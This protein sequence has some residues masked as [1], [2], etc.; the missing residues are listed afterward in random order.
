MKWFNTA[1]K[2]TS[3]DISM[4]FYNSADLPDGITVDMETI[5]FNMYFHMNID[6]VRV[7]TKHIPPRNGI[8]TKFMDFVCDDLRDEIEEMAIA[9][10]KKIKALKYERNTKI[11]DDLLKIVSSINATH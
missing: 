6:G 11:N 2:E 4:M 8:S 3:L 10:N 1:S 5:L 7:A 9:L